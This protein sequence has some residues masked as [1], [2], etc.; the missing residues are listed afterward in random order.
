MF[1]SKGCGSRETKKCRCP[2]QKH[3][4]KFF[5]KQ[6]FCPVE[7]LTP[8]RNPQAVKEIVDRGLKRCIIP[9]SLKR[10]IWI[11]EKRRNKENINVV[12]GSWRWST[13]E[14]PS[15][16]IQSHLQPITRER[17]E[18]KRQQCL[19][20]FNSFNNHLYHHLHMGFTSN[21]VQGM[22]SSLRPGK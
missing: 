15:S 4:W 17:E 11:R 19:Y 8:L 9:P 13:G 5:Q 20:C 10:K 16:G 2:V 1:V 14:S 22:F 21:T 7:K 12:A 18:K 3:S 6:Q